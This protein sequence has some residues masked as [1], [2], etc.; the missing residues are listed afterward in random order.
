MNVWVKQPGHPVIEVEENESEGT[1]TLTQH[2]F[3]RDGTSNGSDRIIYP[4]SLGLMGKDFVD[5]DLKLWVR[6][7]TYDAPLDFYK[8]NAGQTGKSSKFSALPKE[9][10]E[11]LMRSF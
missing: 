6:S 8:L 5:K 10:E 2:R 11:M 3:I 9:A 4:V 1:L 7:K